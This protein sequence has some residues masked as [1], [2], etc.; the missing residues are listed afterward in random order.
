MRACERTCFLILPC[1]GSWSQ[2]NTKIN[3]IFLKEASGSVYCVP[4]PHLNGTTI[5]PCVYLVPKNPFPSSLQITIIK[6]LEYRSAK[7]NNNRSKF[8]RLS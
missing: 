7:I 4:E 2:N 1:V 8:I 3:H 6:T 5:P